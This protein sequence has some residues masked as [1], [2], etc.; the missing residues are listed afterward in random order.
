MG[1]FEQVEWTRAVNECWLIDQAFEGMLRAV[2]TDQDPVPA[3]ARGK[4]VIAE[5][6][7]RALL[8]IGKV[9]GGASYSKS[10]PFGQWAQDVRALGFLRPPWPL[11]YDNL[12]DMS[13]TD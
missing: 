10:G 6:A 13:W 1:A 5:L 9:I 11:A 12:F 4:A 2:E 8:R 7:E 3:A